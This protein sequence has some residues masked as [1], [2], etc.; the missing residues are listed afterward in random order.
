MCEGRHEDDGGVGKQ[1][2][3][4]AAVPAGSDAKHQSG[5]NMVIRVVAIT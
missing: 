4:D 5:R 3:V 2:L 1:S